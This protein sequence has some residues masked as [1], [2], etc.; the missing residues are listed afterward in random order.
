MDIAVEVVCESLRGASP[1]ADSEDR[2]R[3]ALAA[4]HAGCAALEEELR[5]AFEALLP[6]Y[7]ANRLG[8]SLEAGP[9]TSAHAR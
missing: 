7:G 9:R 3:E 4:A 8:A 2:L 6:R 5:A 1:E